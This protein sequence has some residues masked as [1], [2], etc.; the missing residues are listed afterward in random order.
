MFIRYTINISGQSIIKSFN[1]KEKMDVTI[2]VASK[3]PGLYEGPHH[4][5][6][7]VQ[8]V[9]ISFTCLSML[10]VIKLDKSCILLVEQD[11]DTDYIAIHTYQ[12][13]IYVESRQ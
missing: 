12:K 8:P 13:A 10:S 1:K 5:L 9:T 7:S 2:T 6:N 3:P 11:L 4:T